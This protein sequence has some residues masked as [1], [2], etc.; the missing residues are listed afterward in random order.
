M[1]LNTLI[2]R[3]ALIFLIL[4]VIS[5]KLKDWIEFHD[6]DETIPLGVKL[7][8]T[9]TVAWPDL[10]AWLITADFKFYNKTNGWNFETYL[11]KNPSQL[12]TVREFSVDF[13]AKIATNGGFF[14]TSNSKG[15]S[16]SLAEAQGNLLSPNVEKVAR[17]GISYFPTRCAFGIDKSGSANAFWVYKSNTGGTW[18]YENPSNNKQS[19][20][21]QPVPTDTFPS[22]AMSWD[23]KAGVGGGPMLVFNGKNVAMSSYDAEV[24]WGAGV[25]SVVA[26]ARTAIG[27]G[28][29]RK[30]SMD[31]LQLIW[32][33]VDGVGDVTGISLPDLSEEFIE[34]GAIKACN[35]DGGGSTQLVVNQ[36]LVN[37]PDGGDY[38]RALAASAMII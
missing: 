4:A 19:T 17:S 14:G 8:E 28:I 10:H 25:P 7:Y 29:P 36:T 6:F 34:L 24:M 32:I 27:F 20:E 38:E 23:L 18:A 12:S 1:K 30:L 31:S 33:A 21:P 2:L 22:R 13:N 16:Y 35:L 5:A 15:M 37:S 9:T 11:S 3:T 26:A